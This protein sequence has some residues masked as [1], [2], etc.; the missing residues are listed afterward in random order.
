M[1]IQTDSDMNCIVLL[2]EL[3]VDIKKCMDDGDDNDGNNTTS[4]YTASC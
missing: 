1:Q 2:L 4:C 3:L